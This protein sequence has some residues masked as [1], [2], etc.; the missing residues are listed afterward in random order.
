MSSGIGIAR[1]EFDYI[2]LLDVVRLEDTLG[3]PA[4]T[5]PLLLIVQGPCE[6]WTLLS[7]VQSYCSF[8]WSEWRCPLHLSRA[9]CHQVCVWSWTRAHAC[10]YGWAA[11]ICIC[12]WVQLNLLER[13]RIAWIIPYC[14]HLGGP[15]D[16]ALQKRSSLGN[17]HWQP[18]TQ[19][20]HLW[21]NLTKPLVQ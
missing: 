6:W 2:W 14:H 9:F 19:I 7:I 21:C 11:F 5:L 1:L 10:T 15:Q 12:V 8:V 18:S 16:I 4:V 13:G 17:L 3:Q 20:S